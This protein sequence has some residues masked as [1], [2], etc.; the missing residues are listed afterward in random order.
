MNKGLYFLFGT[1]TGVLVGGV[2]TYLYM[3]KKVD[4]VT[5]EINNL[6]EEYGLA[7]DY[8]CNEVNPVD[9][10]EKGEGSGLS[11]QDK[12]EIKQRLEKNYEKTTD[13]AS[14]YKAM[15]YDHPLDDDEE[16]EEEYEDEEAALEAT[17]AHNKNKDKAPKIISA[18]AVGDLDSYIENET[19]FYYKDD[20]V[21]TTEADEEIQDPA[22]YIGDALTKYGFA[23]N[24]ED[25]IHVINYALDTHY[26]IQK[27]FEAW[28]DQK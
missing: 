22:Y 3:R 26:E 12:V 19:L 2:S 11:L 18:E 23:D 1:L 10:E 4:D 6:V 20:G 27:V 5:D 7:S 24:D 16:P 15:N 21:L 13:Y 25:V 14:M 8:E 17:E 28:A 9:D